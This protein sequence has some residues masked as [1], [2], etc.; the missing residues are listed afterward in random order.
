MEHQSAL[1]YG[2]DYNRG[3]LCGMIPNDMNR[4]YIIIHESGHEYF[5]NAVCVKDH[6][7]IWLH[8]SLATY[9]EALYVECT[10][11]CA[12]AVRYLKTQKDN[13]KNLDTRYGTNW[14]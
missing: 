10:Y 3:Y 11:S 6:V 13:I 14:C 2:N 5:G 7:E 12:D 1:A 8:E 9:L 4:N